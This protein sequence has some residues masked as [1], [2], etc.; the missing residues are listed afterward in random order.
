MYGNFVYTYIWLIFTVNV[1]KYTYHTWT[2]QA[3]GRQ[4][5]AA[6]MLSNSCSQRISNSAGCNAALSGAK[7][8]QWQHVVSMTQV[9]FRGEHGDGI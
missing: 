9:A 8:G 6:Q 7:R 4:R 5:L 1:G 2:L 3:G